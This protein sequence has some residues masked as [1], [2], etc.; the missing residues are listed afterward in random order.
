M[1][2]VKHKE[3]SRKNKTKFYYLSLAQLT[4]ITAAAV[5]PTKVQCCP[6]MAT[7]VT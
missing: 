1:S 2:I 5:A 4:T 3:Y 6:S 7:L